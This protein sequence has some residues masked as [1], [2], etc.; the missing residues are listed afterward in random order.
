M[1]GFA[2]VFRLG[3]DRV[4]KIAHVAH[5]LARARIAREAE[6]LAAV[7]SP[8]VPKLHGSG[9]L[10]DGRAWLVMDRIGGT[11]V[12]DLTTEGPMP[13]PDATMIG[14]AMLESLAKIHAASFV[15]R[16]LKPDNLFRNPE[17]GIVILDLGLARKLPTDVHDP[18]RE[19]VVVGSIEYMPPEQIADSASV[20]ER[21]DLYAFGCVLFELLAGRPPFLG[22]GAA[23][24]RAHTAL[25]PPRLD[26]LIDVPAGIDQ[27][28]HDCLAKDPARRPGSALRARSLLMQDR[29]SSGRSFATQPISI[30]RES[31]QPVVIVYAVLP[32]V[33]RALLGMFAARRLVVASQRGRR[34]IAAA[35]G[36]EHGDPATIAIAAARDLAAAGARVALHLEALRVGSE[37]SGPS[38][39]GEAIE[40]PEAWLPVGTWTGVLVTRALASVLQSPTRDTA[41]HPGFR[42]LAEEAERAELIGRE[43]LIGDL[44]SDAAA[45][46]LGTMSAAPATGPVTIANGVAQPYLVTRERV[47]GPGFSLVVGDAGVGKTAL[48]AELAVRLRDL[49]VDVHLGTVALPGTGKPSYAAL[50]ELVDTSVGNNLIRTLGDALRTRAR[51]RPLAVI[52]DDLQLA[53]HD[54]LDALEYATLGGEALPLW[55][56][57]IAGPRIDARRPN[58]G[59]RAESNRRFVLEPLDDEAAVALAAKLLEPAEY[60]PLR[61]LRRLVGIARGNPLHLATLTRDLHERGAIRDRAGGVPYFDTSMLEELSPAALGPWLA[62]RELSGLA[63]ELVALARICAVLGG[64]IQ[65]D[66]LTAIVEAVERAGGATTTIDAGVGLHEL[67]VAGLLVASKH[68][69]QFSQALVEEGIYATTDEAERLTIHRAAL[70]W[71]GPRVEDVAAAERVARHAER[72]GEAAIAARAFGVVARHAQVA[73]RLIEAEQARQGELRNLPANNA[74]RVRA[75]LGRA[76]ARSHQQRS[77]IAIEDA[78]AAVEISITLGDPELEIEARLAL[79]RVLDLAT[80]FDRSRDMTETALAKLATVASATPELRREAALAQARSAFRAEDFVETTQQLRAIV[81]QPTED[82]YE[83]E[84]V[85]ALIYGPS[86]ARLGELAEA[87]K[88]FAD[89][90]ARCVARDDLFHLCAAYGN[91]NWLWSANGMV[92]RAAEDLRL[93]IQVAREAGL[94]GLERVATWNLAEDRLWQ[95]SLEE[96]LRLARR[97]LA[98]QSGHGDGNTQP[99]RMLLAR[100]LAARSEYPELHDLVRALREEGFDGADL[101][102]IELLEAAIV[103]APVVRWDELLAKIDTLDEGTQL[104][105][106]HLAARHH[107]LHGD[108]RGK[109]AALVAGAPIWAPRIHEFEPLPRD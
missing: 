82:G 99:D 13:V 47:G 61:A 91:R 100:V 2:T 10:D 96:A 3:D 38:V 103:D 97:S 12:T 34:V 92:E 102:M 45:A 20:D 26:S 39:E 108:A 87:E 7:G 37:A 72:V 14:I 93:T 62:A 33:D 101:A 30:L 17:T 25:R 63:V 106:W 9:I 49:D 29:S 84:V 75:L 16:D 68:G 5:D 22:D 71:W 83:V 24:E 44:M 42:A 51:A 53:D 55:V 66:E 52:L 88:V 70:G 98:L 77:E 50:G 67:E 79:S 15:H 107:R 60:P 19:G 4:V 57:G 105:L 94:P 54:L 104:E 28:V 21:S 40:K 11:T 90:I 58:L 31:K 64:E 59:R 69:A 86:L 48:A 35:L 109:I 32:R 6:A 76:D 18:T 27:L 80:D 85:A 23:L 81:N 56:L 65:R 95:G 1:G 89:L 46:L 43:R 8:A 36:G 41:E 74:D 78:E 73:H